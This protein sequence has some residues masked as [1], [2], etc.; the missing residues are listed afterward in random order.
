MKMSD[1]EFIRYSRQI[2]LPN[3]GE[4][5]Q[6][7]FKKSQAIVIGIGGLGTLVAHYLAAAGVGEIELVDGDKIES[8]NLP[9]QLL[10]SDKDIG[11]N[12]ATVAFTKLQQQYPNT[13]ISVRAEMFSDQFQL[14]ITKRTIF[15]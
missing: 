7:N 8:S 10:F 13:H 6:I 2:L 15:F 9:R 14:D 5:G 1:K 3:V 4:Q 11:N 12:K